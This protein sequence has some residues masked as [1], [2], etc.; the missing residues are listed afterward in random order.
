MSL[1]CRSLQS[2]RKVHYLDHMWIEFSEDILV[3]GAWVLCKENSKVNVLE[4]SIGSKF[5]GGTL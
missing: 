4:S 1:L 2:V 5:L 3:S